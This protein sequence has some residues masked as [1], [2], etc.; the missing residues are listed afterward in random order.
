MFDDFDLLDYEEEDDISFG[1]IAELT[2]VWTD[3]KGYYASIHSLGF[4]NFLLKPEIL[5]AIADCGFE[6]PSEVQHECLPQA[7]LGMSDMGKTGVFIIST[8]QQLEPDQNV[9]CVLVLCH[10]RELIFRVSIEY[11]RFSK[12]IPNLKVQV[13]FGGLPFQSDVEILKARKPHI[14][15]GTPGRILA[16]MR[17]KKLNLQY[18]KHLILDEYD[19]M[20]NQKEVYGNIREIFNST[21]HT[22]QVL[23]FSATISNEVRLIC[24]KFMQNSMEV[25]VDDEAK[26]TLHGLQQHCVE[27][28]ENEKNRKLFDLLDVLE[29]NQVVIFVKSVQRCKTLVGLLNGQHFPA[30]GIHRDMAQL[31]RLKR[32]QQFKDFEKRVLVAT[33]LFGRGLDIARVKSYS[34]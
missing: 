32:Y 6:H 31:E 3:V 21:P 18:L 30:I 28:M 23:M 11:E 1:S 29:F 15:V 27:L 7:I 5:Q 26:L 10:I 24:K 13:L 33:N 17:N 14:L 22:K 20:L 16:L 9:P 34:L 12:Y 19:Q 8:L 25:F 4:R 2:T